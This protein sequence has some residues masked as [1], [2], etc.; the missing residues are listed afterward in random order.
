MDTYQHNELLSQGVKYIRK[1]KN[2]SV[3]KKDQQKVAEVNSSFDTTCRMRA[4]ELIDN[5]KARLEAEVKDTNSNE[6]LICGNNEQHTS[7]PNNNQTSHKRNNLV[8]E[9]NTNELIEF[10]QKRNLSLNADYFEVLSN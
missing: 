10:L 9:K 4:Q 7:L 6:N 8:E 1:S 2:S 3:V 5:W